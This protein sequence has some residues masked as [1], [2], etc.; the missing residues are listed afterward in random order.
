MLPLPGQKPNKKPALGR[1]LWVFLDYL[2]VFDGG[3]EEDRTPDL[4]I[5]NAALSQL[6]YPPDVGAIL[7]HPESLIKASAPTGTDTMK[8]CL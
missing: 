3:E 4:R 7:Y 6:S 5:A 1:V 8:P 2:K